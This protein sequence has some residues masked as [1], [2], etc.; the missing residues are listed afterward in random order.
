MA[1]SADATSVASLPNELLALI[2]GVADRKTVAALACVSETHAIA[3]RVLYQFHVDEGATLHWAA[4]EN[5]VELVKRVLAHGNHES[6]NRS[7]SVGAGVYFIPITTLR[8]RGVWATP[9]HLAAAYGHDDVVAVLLDAGAEIN[10]LSNPESAGDF[11][12]LSPLYGAI[13]RG[14][15]PTAKL[16]I[17]RGASLFVAG[18]QPLTIASMPHHVRAGEGLIA[19]HIAVHGDRARFVSF[20]LRQPGVDPNVQGVDGITPLHLA[21]DTLVDLDTIRVLLGAGADPNMVVSSSQ[22]SS[23][24]L[25]AA[26]SSYSGIQA[27][28]ML[29]AGG[30][31]IEARDLDG[32]T[33]LLH[34]CKFESSS[35]IRFL[36]ASGAN[37]N[38]PLLVGGGGNGQSNFDAIAH[39]LGNLDS[40]ASIVDACTGRA[41]ISDA[42]R[43]RIHQA[44]GDLIERG[45]RPQVN[46]VKAFLHC[47]LPEMAEILL[48]GTH[49]ASRRNTYWIYSYKLAALEGRMYA[50]DFLLRYFPPPMEQ[51]GRLKGGVSRQWTELFRYMIGTRAIDHPKI[52]SILQ[53]NLD[54]YV[55]EYVDGGLVAALINSKAYSYQKHGSLLRNLLY[56]KNRSQYDYREHRSLMQRHFDKH[57][58]HNG[59][60]DATAILDMVLKSGLELCVLDG[61]PGQSLVKSLMIIS[62][63]H[64]PV[65]GQADVMRKII[66]VDVDWRIRRDVILGGL[67]KELRDSQRQVVE[68]FLGHED[69]DDT[70]VDLTDLF[71]SNDE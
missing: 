62:S 40:L 5:D 43:D 71:E 31:N 23:L 17:D 25:A 53:T 24:H 61:S 1:S 35:A 52:W 65:K 2:I 37:P 30:G 60:G 50:L 41:F 70:I 63:D 39:I 9:L 66:R 51:D 18:S 29:L 4:R 32:R 48:Q 54:E 3:T 8:C 69:E 38:P 22:E 59:R 68:G 34:A 64:Y 11:H 57:F 49:C 42:R 12:R 15:L 47:N 14:H 45:A 26:K 13:S 27:L 19:S 6:L 58:L 20:L 55:H 44:L 28:K 46:T 56:V 67:P 10:R 7:I 16:L 33:P 36:L 21:C